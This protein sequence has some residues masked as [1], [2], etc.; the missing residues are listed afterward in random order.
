MRTIFFVIVVL[1]LFLVPACHYA[2][3]MMPEVPQ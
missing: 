1:L 3:K 2:L